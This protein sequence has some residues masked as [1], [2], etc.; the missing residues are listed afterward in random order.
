MHQIAFINHK[1]KFGLDFHT[2]VQK[3]GAIIQ[4]PMLNLL[5]LVGTPKQT[6]GRLQSQPRF[7]ITY[8]YPKKSCIIIDDV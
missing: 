5:P 8:G 3:L 7:E 2:I 4:K 6:N 1:T